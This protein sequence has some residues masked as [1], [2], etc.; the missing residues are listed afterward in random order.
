MVIKTENGFKYIEEDEEDCEYT[1]ADY[2][3]C[4]DDGQPKYDGILPDTATFLL[5]PS[6]K[7]E[8][9]SY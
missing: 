2:L 5:N 3:D 9:V 1:A 4:F 6:V 8:N 7:T